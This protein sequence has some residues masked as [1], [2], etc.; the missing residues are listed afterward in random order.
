M[1]ETLQEIKSL[2]A[3]NGIEVKECGNGHIQLRKGKTVVNYYPW[4]KQMTAWDA[5]AKERHK[6]VCPEEAMAIVLRS[7]PKEKG[8][9]S[10]KPVKAPVAPRESLQTNPAGIK[11]LYEGGTPPWDFPTFICS[12]SDRKRMAAYR[13][14]RRADDLEENANAQEKRQ[15]TSLT[16]LQIAAKEMQTRHGL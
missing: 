16:P 9:R 2:A 1:N 4:S 14:R 13:L 5:S 10:P 15:Q 7:L 3:L 6:H 12:D 8:K 11:N